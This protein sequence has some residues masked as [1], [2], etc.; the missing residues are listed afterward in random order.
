VAYFD[1]SRDVCGLF[2][3]TIRDLVSAGVPTD[4]RAGYL[5]IRHQKC[6]QL[7]KPLSASSETAKAQEQPIITGH[8]ITA[9]GTRLLVHATFQFGVS[10]LTFRRNVLLPSSGQKSENSKQRLILVCCL[11]GVAFGSDGM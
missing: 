5:L 4:I 11:L 8:D 10:S 1:F 6:N 9:S 3:E 2:A 7:R